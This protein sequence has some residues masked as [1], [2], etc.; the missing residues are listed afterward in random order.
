MNAWSKWNIPSHFKKKIW[1]DG[2]LNNTNF[3]WDL[4]CVCSPAGWVPRL[5]PS[6]QKENDPPVTVQPPF[7]G[8]H[9]ARCPVCSAVLL[10]HGSETQLYLSRAADVWQTTGINKENTEHDVAERL[11]KHTNQRYLIS[12]TVRKEFYL[13]TSLL[14]VVGYVANLYKMTVTLLSAAKGL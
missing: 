13:S 5:A 3:W 1:H 12:V 11:Y 9:F 7:S 10:T 2:G 4:T 8:L 6:P 14:F